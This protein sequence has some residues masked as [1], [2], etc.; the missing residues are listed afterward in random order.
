MIEFFDKPIPFSKISKDFYRQPYESN[1]SKKINKHKSIIIGYASKVNI[2]L[3][4]ITIIV[5][6]VNNN[7]DKILSSRE[8]TIGLNLKKNKIYKKL[9]GKGLDGYMDSFNSLETLYQLVG[10]LNEKISID[11][12]LYLNNGYKDLFDDIINHYNDPNRIPYDNLIEGVIG[13][14]CGEII[15]KIRINKIAKII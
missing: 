8:V 2:H 7:G 3:S 14:V 9:Q 1:R 12:M 10:L 4:I 5:V 6:L 15:R 13:N 11:L